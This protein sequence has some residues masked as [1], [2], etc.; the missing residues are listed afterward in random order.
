MHS[1]RFALLLSVAALALSASPVW[2]DAFVNFFRHQKIGQEIKVQGPFWRDPHQ[3]DLFK[4][5]DKTGKVEYYTF[6]ATVILPT[7]LIG[8]GSLIQRVQRLDIMVVLYPD[9]SVVKDLPVEGDNV[10]FIGTL[11]GYQY[12]REG[13]TT[14]VGTGGYPYILLK[15]L[16]PAEPEKPPFSP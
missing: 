2:A 8:N 10:W 5:D 4:K 14:G 12:G 15:S 9:E 6:F 16:E 3:R 11:L 13:I 7:H 1:P